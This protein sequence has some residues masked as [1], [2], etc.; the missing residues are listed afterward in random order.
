MVTIIIP[1]YNESENIQNLIN[2][3]L[4]HVDVNI[5]VVDDNSPDGTAVVVRKIKDKRVKLLLRKNK[6]GLG[7][8]IKDGLL[9]SKGM[10]GVMDADFSHPPDVLPEMLRQI[11]DNDIVVG[12]RKVKG[13]GTKKWPFNRKLVSFIATMLAKPLTNVK[14]PVSGFFFIR[15]QVIDGIKLNEQSCKMCLEILVKGK[16]NKVKEVPIV[17]VNR[18][19]G[20]SK[21]LNKGEFINYLKHLGSLYRYKIK[22]KFVR[23]Q[24]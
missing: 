13:G 9:A 15:K 4:K 6:K 17:F 12:S 16:Y 21:I 22:R 19:K 23:G 11:E 24:R 18:K 1:T 2:E 10:V 8:A 14:D 3:I 5:L 7:S 20:R